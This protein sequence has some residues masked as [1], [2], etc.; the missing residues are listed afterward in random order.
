MGQFTIDLDESI[1]A[2]WYALSAVKT[3]KRYEPLKQSSQFLCV[4]CELELLPSLSV[5]S[6][7]VGTS[8]HLSRSAFL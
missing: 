4:Q 5:A 8:T 7:S 6:E 1:A 2:L 3:V